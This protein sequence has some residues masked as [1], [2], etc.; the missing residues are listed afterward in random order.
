MNICEYGRRLQ[1]KKMCLRVYIYIYTDF[2]LRRLVIKR[3]CYSPE[4]VLFKAFR[5]LARHDNSRREQ[6]KSQKTFEIEQKKHRR[7]PQNTPTWV[8]GKVLGE[9]FRGVGSRPDFG[10]LFGLFWCLL[11]SLGDHVGFFGGQKHH[12]E[13]VSI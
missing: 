13:S 2:L 7:T 12:K 10:S 4:L 5:N 3:V 9:S 8:F 1:R 11:G 6:K